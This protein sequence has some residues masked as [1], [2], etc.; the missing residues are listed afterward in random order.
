MR[1]MCVEPKK[2]LGNRDLFKIGKI[3]KQMVDKESVPPMWFGGG[4]YETSWTTR[5]NR[6]NLGDGGV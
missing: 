6:G 5:S 3:A 2:F 1:G 4:L